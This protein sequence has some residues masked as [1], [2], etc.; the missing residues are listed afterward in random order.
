MLKGAV[1]GDKVLVKQMPSKGSSPEGE[2]VRVIAAQNAMLTGVVIEQEGAYY[3]KPDSMPEI[4][5]KIVRDGLGEAKIGDKVAAELVYRSDRH[6]YHKVNVITIFGDSETAAACAQSILAANSIET[7]FPDEVTAMA[8]KLQAAGI[9]KAE[10]SG[11]TDLRDEIIFTI[12]GADTKDIDDAIS[13]T[14]TSEGYKLGVHIADVSHY[15]TEKSV[16]DE[17]AFARG[18]SVYF[19]DS[20]VPMLPKALSNGIC[21]LNPNEDRLAFSCL[22][23]L[24]KRGKMTSHRFEKTVIRS[25][26]K[27]VYTEV[28]AILE[29]SADEAV[30]GK[31]AEALE[32]IKLMEQLA[33]VLITRRKNRGAPDLDTTESKIIIGADGTA[34]DVKPRQRGFSERIIE[35][36]M[37]C[38]NEAAALFS[39][40]KL[41]PFV[42]RVHESPNPEKILNLSET[43]RMLGL[44]ATP[45]RGSVEPK[46]ITAVLNQVKGTPLQ[47]PVTNSVLRAMAKAKYSDNPIGHFGLVLGNYSH[48]TSPIRRYPDLAIHRILSEYLESENVL[49]IDKHYASYAKAVGVSSS[50]SE[51]RAM[52]AERD[53]ED[54]YKAEFMKK[55]IGE[56]FDGTVSSVAP[57]GVYV[58]LENTVEGLV[59]LSALPAD[60]YEFDGRISMVSKH[61]KAFTIGD[62]IRIKVV[63]A[64]VCEGNIDFELV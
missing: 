46:D 32:T 1:T 63:N 8:D 51:L 35:E 18:T 41:L 3:L 7:V 19:A 2:V 27:G 14:K 56:E 24:D 47:R 61:A 28:N 60:D 54:C 29:G 26:I 44:D 20:V 30:M 21:S 42:Y 57:H 37:L 52:T 12:D 11:R 5:V 17:D 16:I 33:K 50:A 40:E 10:I 36:F 23:E 55:H 45:L 39:R 59:K 6:M 53:C 38:A 58:E 49:Y 64:N 13:L 22:M 43:M 15:V 25:R 4:P 62:N 48:F 9:S 31:Y 34:V